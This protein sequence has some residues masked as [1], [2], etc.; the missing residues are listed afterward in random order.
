[1]YANEMWSD[2]QNTET[3]GNSGM[4]ERF[5]R[6]N[7]AIEANRWEFHFRP[8]VA[9]FLERENLNCFLELGKKWTT[10]R[11][12][13][14]SETEPAWW[15]WRCFISERKKK[16]RDGSARRASH[17]SQHKEMKLKVQVIHILKPALT[18]GLLSEHL[19]WSAAFLFCAK[20]HGETLKGFLFQDGNPS[21]SIGKPQWD[22][23]NCYLSK[24]HN[25]SLN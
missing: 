14:K 21:N 17:N 22:L 8:I 3:N 23:S 12:E 19:R 6:E 24:R 25:G 9:T 1:M 5:Q 13:E 18:H 7:K 11:G 15:S 2:H 16:A 10:N 20:V 4:R